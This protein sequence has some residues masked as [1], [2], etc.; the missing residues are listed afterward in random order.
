MYKYSFFKD[1]NWT[2]WSHISIAECRNQNDSETYILLL[3]FKQFSS[4][5]LKHSITLFFSICLLFIS[6]RQAENNEIGILLKLCYEQW[7]YDEQIS[8]TPEHSYKS[9]KILWNEDTGRPFNSVTSSFCV[10][11]G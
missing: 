8:K 4:H 3:G 9:H 7:N 1:N 10:W 5:P 6:C 11:D 2:K